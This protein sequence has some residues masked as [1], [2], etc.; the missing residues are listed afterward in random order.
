MP[1]PS[2]LGEVAGKLPNQGLEHGTSATK[3]WGGTT[4]GRGL[5]A[6]QCPFKEPLLAAPGAASYP[7]LLS[8]CLQTPPGRCGDGTSGLSETR[9][10]TPVTP[11]GAHCSLN[12]KHHC[13]PNV[14]TQ[15]RGFKLVPIV[16]VHHNAS[17]EVM[18]GNDLLVCLDCPSLGTNNVSKMGRITQRRQ[19]S[20]E[21]AGEGSGDQ[22]WVLG[23]LPGSWERSL[24]V[25]PGSWFPRCGQSVG[26]HRATRIRSVHAPRGC[27][28]TTR[29][30]KSQRAGWVEAKGS[31]S[32]LSTWLTCQGVPLRSSE[33]RFE[34]AEAVRG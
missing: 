16:P 10:R 4:L 21:R 7:A 15:G 33:Q 9:L 3:C 27:Y 19:K 23:R 18:D 5:A 22:K 32:C 24:W 30:E 20:G 8:L 11:R 17:R 1:G 29:E 34:G 6:R 14:R 28:F 31:S 12:Q 2:W 13:S 26:I 25:F